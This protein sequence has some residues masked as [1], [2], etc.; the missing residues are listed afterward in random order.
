MKIALIREGKIPHDSR[1]PLTPDQCDYIQRHFPVQ[2]TVQPSPIRCFGDEEYAETG[3]SLSEDVSHCDLLLGVKEVPVSQLLSHKSYCFFS[4]TIKKQPHN[5][6]LLRAILDMDIRLIDYELLTDA[7]GERLIAFGHFAGIV[8]AYNGLYAY[9]ER[10]GAFRLKRLYQCLDYAEA[11]QQVDQIQLPP[12]RIVLTGTGRV[13]SGAR[14][15]L[16]D[17]GIREVSPAEYLSQTFEEPVFTQ[18]KSSDYAAPGDGS[19]FSR[20]GFYAHPESYVSIFEPYTHNTDLFINGIFWDSRAPAFFTLEDMKKPDFRIRTIADITC[21]IAPQSSVPS[22]LRASTIADPIY[23]FDP[24]TEKETSP[25]QDKVIDVMAIDNLPNELPRDASQAFGNQFIRH[26][27]PELLQPRSE[28]IDR[29]TIAQNGHLQERFHYLSDY[30]AG[31][32]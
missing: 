10:T 25:Y 24:F 13:S 27:L 19:A 14:E 29:A 32:L 18:L 31:V 9:G 7:S 15:V 17:F 8:G 16:E 3:I 28:I 20:E 22:T 1:V 11:L 23:G 5:Q 2:I 26:I 30:A 12:L 4:H 6:N 21:D